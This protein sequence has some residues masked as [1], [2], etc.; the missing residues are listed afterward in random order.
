ML[1]QV[2]LK[3]KSSIDFLLNLSNKN[4]KLA[5]WILFFLSITVYFCF[6]NYLKVLL[7][8]PDEFIYYGLARSFSQLKGLNLHNLPFNNQKIFYDLF[9][10]PVFFF[11]IKSYK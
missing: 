1:K 5:L 10:M 11:Q 2:K 9:L 4:L 7:V 6:S 8:Y 3:I